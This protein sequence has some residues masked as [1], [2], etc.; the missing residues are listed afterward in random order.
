MK[1]SVVLYLAAF[2]TVFAVQSTKADLIEA[3]DFFSLP[4]TTASTATPSTIAATVGSGSLDISAFTLGSPQGTNPE[5]TSFAGSQ[6]NTFTGSVDTT[7]SGTAL[8]LANSLANGKSLIFSFDFSGFEDLVVSFAT[9]GTSTGFDSGV[10]SWSTDG[11][12]Y[13]TLIG[14][15]TATRNTTFATATADFSAA[16]GLDN[17]STAF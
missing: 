11:V 17:A 2:L 10:W 13:T 9:R 14:V 16:S 4:A 6:L 12:G 7:G 1:K 8:A 15:N 5:R 3:W